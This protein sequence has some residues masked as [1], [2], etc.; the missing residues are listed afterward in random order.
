MARLSAGILRVLVAMAL[1]A[2]PGGGMT[3]A[4]ASVRHPWHPPKVQKVTVLPR[5]AAKIARHDWKLGRV[6]EGPLK[7]AAWPVP[8]S[9]TVAVSGR[10]TR[11]G[12][13][14]VLAA[15]PAG[16][17]LVGARVRVLAHAAATRLGLDGVVFTVS[18]AGMGGGLADATCTN[19][20]QPC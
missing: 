16:Q 9:A 12:A 8:R 17:G 7:H 4:T 20:Y 14:P 6:P 10:L 18:S 13:T 19:P 5:V 1:V 11:A 3:P 2:M 15:A